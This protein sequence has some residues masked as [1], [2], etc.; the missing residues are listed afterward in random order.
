[1]FKNLTDLLIHEIRDLY[2]A[3]T[4]LLDALPKMADA[5]S[6]EDLKA[7]FRDHLKETENHVTRLR[8]AGRH[9][10]ISVEGETC[11]AMK[12]LIKEGEEAIQKLGDPTVKDALLIASAQRVEHYEIA[13]YGSAAC[14]AHCSDLG[15][16]QK[17]LEETLDEEKDADSKLNKLARGGMLSSGINQAASA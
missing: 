6:D 15:D 14:F 8:E 2:S 13:A 17:I 12:G 16:V 7:A 4:Q 5:A 9:L 1:M 11:N 3:E 10:H